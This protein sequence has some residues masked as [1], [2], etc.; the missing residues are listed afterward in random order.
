MFPEISSKSKPP[1]MWRSPATRCA[2]ALASDF[3]GDSRPVDGD[4]DQV[5]TVD[6]GADELAYGINLLVDGGDLQEC[7]SPQ[8]NTVMVSSLVFPEG[9]QLVS[10]ELFLNGKSV[11]TTLPAEVVLVLGVTRSQ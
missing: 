11:A 8:G 3:E 4:G 10:S 6:I 1:S 5:A 7:Q 2:S 9:I